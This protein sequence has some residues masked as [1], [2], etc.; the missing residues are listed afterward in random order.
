MA[1]VDGSLAL[2]GGSQLDFDGIFVL[3]NHLLVLFDG[4]LMLF[5]VTSF[6][7]WGSR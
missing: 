6:C 4:S 5:D 2:V 1:V 7:G 3:V